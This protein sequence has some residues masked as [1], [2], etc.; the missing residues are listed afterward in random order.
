MVGGGD[1]VAADRSRRPRRIA[2]QSIPSQ[3]PSD[4]AAPTPKIPRGTHLAASRTS[5][6]SEFRP[7]RPQGDLIPA[8]NRMHHVQ[9]AS[10]IA[11]RCP[12][13]VVDDDA[14]APSWSSSPAPCLPYT[15]RSTVYARAPSTRTLRPFPPLPTPRGHPPQ[16]PPPPFPRR[17][18]YGSPSPYAYAYRVPVRLQPTHTPGPKLALLRPLTPTPRTLD[19]HHHIPFASAF[20]SP[21]QPAAYPNSITHRRCHVRESH[22]PHSGV[23]FTLTP[24]PAIST[25]LSTGLGSLAHYVPE[26]FGAPWSHTPA[27]ELEPSPQTMKLEA[28][29]SKPFARVHWV[30]RVQTARIMKSERAV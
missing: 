12:P 18:P 21:P 20:L 26:R 29:E 28:G 10:P 30:L 7:R 22:L 11:S 14:E 2:P 17:M 3:N 5:Q 4:F 19:L 1:R 23:N 6:I 8:P 16:P 9:I 27:R 24:T 15:P 25:S 13:R